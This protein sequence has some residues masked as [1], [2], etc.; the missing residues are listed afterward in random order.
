MTILNTLQGTAKC[1]KCRGV[2]DPLT[3]L[4]PAGHDGMMRKFRCSSCHTE[5]YYL[6]PSSEALDK[7]HSRVK[8]LLELE[9]ILDTK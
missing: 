8:A 1:L 9:A 2:S 7:V 6:V 5:F 4:P 3:W